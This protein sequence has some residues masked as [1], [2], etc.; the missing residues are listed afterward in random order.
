MPIE[1]QLRHGK[2]KVKLLKDSVRTLIYIA[3]TIVYYNPLKLFLLFALGCVGV[4]ALCFGVGVLLKIAAPYYLGIG[5][6]LLS[7]LMFGLGLI[8]DLLRQIMLRTAVGP[9]ERLT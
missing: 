6:L 7:V 9:P 8:A 2:S 4:A 1:Y 3:Q 5:S